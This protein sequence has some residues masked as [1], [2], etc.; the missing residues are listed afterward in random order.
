MKERGTGE[1]RE[2]RK[3][4]VTLSHTHA[5]THAHNALSAI[6]DVTHLVVESDS[7]LNKLDATY[8]LYLSTPPE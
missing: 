8:S 5:R 6:L 7:D 4:G 1:G 2:G 3:D